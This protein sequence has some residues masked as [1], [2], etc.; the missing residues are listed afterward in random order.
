M[1]LRR[2]SLVGFSLVEVLFA[3]S[4]LVMVGLAMSALN[5]AAARLITTTELKVAAYAMND[6]SLAYVA[7]LRKANGAAFSVAPCSLGTPCY[8]VCPA[9]NLAANCS[10]SVTPKAVQLGR[11][12]VQF[13]PEVKVTQTG[14]S[15]LVLAK[16]SWGRGQNRSVISS[17]LLE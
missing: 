2:H 15:Y 10:F 13:V 12:R 6:Q 11:N 8:V 7:I 9:D 17:Q 1:K 4:F 14:S 16:T 3:V 5:S